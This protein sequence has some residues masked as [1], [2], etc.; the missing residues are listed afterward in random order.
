MDGTI[1]NVTFNRKLL[2][3]QFKIISCLYIVLELED[4]SKDIKNIKQM[5]DNIRIKNSIRKITNDTEKSLEVLHE[6]CTLKLLKL[7]GKMV[8]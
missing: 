3:W 7:N 8:K 4:N 2:F 5:L 6:G 1:R